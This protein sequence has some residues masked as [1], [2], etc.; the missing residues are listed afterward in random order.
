[1]SYDTPRLYVACLAAYN[2][3]ILHGRWIDASTDVDEMQEEIEAMLKESPV[4]EAEEWAI[5]DSEGFGRE[6]VEEYTGLE[7]I[8]RMIEF[9]EEHGKL[10]VPVLEYC[11][12]DVVDA[13]QTIENYV[14]MHESL[15]DYARELTEECYTIPDN[16][17]HYIDYEAMARDMAINDVMTI[18]TAWNEVHIFMRH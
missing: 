12:G 14:G 16:L 5:H 15:E 4:P 10:G 7:H 11:C 9:I 18:E 6:L 17:A 1:M 8:V 3:G 13:R 2:N